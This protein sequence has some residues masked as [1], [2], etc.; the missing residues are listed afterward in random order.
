MATTV[1]EYVAERGI[2]VLLHFTRAKN[3]ASILARGLVPRN[4]LLLE[5]YTDYNDQHRI[6]QTD[7][8]CL[9]IG[10]PNYKMFYGIKKDYPEETWVVL[11][12]RPAA[13]WTLECAFCTANAASNSVTAIPLDQRKGLAA[14]QAMYGDWPTQPR[15]E[16]SIPDQYPTN[17]QAEVLMLNGVPRNYIVGIITLN[18]AV[19]Q[20]L[21]AKYPGVDI[22]ALAG[23]FRYR[24][25][26]AYWQ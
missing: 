4:T 12:I 9:S 3:L 21:F 26:Y 10:F 14:M 18:E 25:D 24:K 17:P 19:K 13:L 20:Q 11:A 2:K 15:A 5:G 6:D 8:V 7:A 1:Q 22:R 23:Y 16:L